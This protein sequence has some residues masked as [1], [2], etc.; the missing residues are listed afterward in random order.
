MFLHLIFLVDI[1]PSYEVMSY[2]FLH[3]TYFV[4]TS[5]EFGRFDFIV[6]GAAFVVFLFVCFFQEKKRV[7]NIDQDSLISLPLEH[8]NNLI[9]R[10]IELSHEQTLTS[11]NSNG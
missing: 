3:Y 2:A 9:Q 7:H 8:L 5:S 11:S 10:I 6:Y 4:K 1:I